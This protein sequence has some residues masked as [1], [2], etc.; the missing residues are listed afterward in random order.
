MELVGGLT[1]MKDQ[2]VGLD[3]D[4]VQLGCQLFFPKVYKGKSKPNIVKY[5]LVKYLVY[6]K[7]HFIEKK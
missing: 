6:L 2:V 4:L 1:S 7:E 3:C 5:I